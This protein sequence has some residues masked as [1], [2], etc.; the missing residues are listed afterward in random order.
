MSVTSVGPVTAENAP[1]L[2]M[3]K[4]TCSQ[5]VAELKGKDEA[6]R[7]ALEDTYVLVIRKN[8]TGRGGIIDKSMC[9]RG[10]CCQGFF[11][12]CWKQQANTSRSR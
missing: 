7:Q 10:V 2:A 11:W 4:K 1:A 12:T 8:K 3:L 6:G 5:L 9:Y